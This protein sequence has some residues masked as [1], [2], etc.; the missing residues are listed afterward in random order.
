VDYDFLISSTGTTCR[1]VGILETKNKKL[2]AL[3][4]NK[5]HADLIEI[6]NKSASSR[7]ADDGKKISKLRPNFSLIF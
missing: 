3:R 1:V 4:E 7:D 5:K 2:L 6:M